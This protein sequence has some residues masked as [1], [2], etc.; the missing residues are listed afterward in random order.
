[1]RNLFLIIAG[2]AVLLGLNSYY[3][4]C[5]NWIAMAVAIIFFYI[6]IK[7]FVSDYTHYRFSD[8]S[9]VGCAWIVLIVGSVV[10]YGISYCSGIAW[11]KH[12]AIM[13]FVPG[14]DMFIGAISY[15]G[16]Y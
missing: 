8:N 10:S 5:Q 7:E 16:Y 15:D 2:S 9:F 11:C 1:M 12:L 6:Y 4:V 14:V 13:M 3:G